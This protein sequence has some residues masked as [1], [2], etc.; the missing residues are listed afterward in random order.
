M[1]DPRIIH[2]DAV[3]ER[4]ERIAK[5]AET[6]E[7]EIRTANRHFAEEVSEAH[8]MFTLRISGHPLE[9]S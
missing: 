5:A 2:E 1:T 8:R 3:R 4:L 6:L 7:E 9:E